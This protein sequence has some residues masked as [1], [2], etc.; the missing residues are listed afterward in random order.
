MVKPNEIK[1]L[2]RSPSNSIFG[3]PTFLDGA[4]SSRVWSIEERFSGLLTIFG[5]FG[6][7]CFTKVIFFVF[8]LSLVANFEMILNERRVDPNQIINEH[9]WEKPSVVFHLM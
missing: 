1:F 9:Q 5:V 7:T 2:A 8:F 4:K 6:F 3:R